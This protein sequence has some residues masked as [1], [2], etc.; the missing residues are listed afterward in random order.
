MKKIFLKIT[1]SCF[2][3]VLLILGSWMLDGGG[4]Y[5]SNY[6]EVKSVVTQYY[7]TL[8]DEDAV[9]LSLTTVGS[10]DKVPAKRELVS[11]HIKKVYFEQVDGEIKAIAEARLISA[12]K[13]EPLEV[14]WTLR[15]IDNNWKIE[16]Q[17]E[18][19]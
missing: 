3:I 14:Y 1:A 7:T 19:D 8:R 18:M 9:D 6:L 16:Y 2:I 5:I 12:D 15:K 10:I 17:E 13:A 11:F 4:E